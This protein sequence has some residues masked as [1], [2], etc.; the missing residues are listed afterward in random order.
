MDGT[1]RTAQRVVVIGGGVAGL[2]VAARLAQAGVPVTLLEASRLGLAASTRNQGWL[3]SGAWFALEQPELARMCFESLDV[4]RRFCPDCLDD[5]HEGMAFLISKPDTLATTWT[6][7]W[8]GVGIPFEEIPRSKLFSLVDG[9][10]QSLVHHAWLLPDRAFRP[11]VLLTR[12]ASAATNAGA[13]IRTET[14][15]SKL[16]REGDRVVEVLTGTGETIAARFVILA[17]DA[18]GHELLSEYSADVPG[19]QPSYTLVAVKSHLMAL[20][21]E[22]CSLPFCVVDRGGFNHVPHGPASVFG[23]NRW[24]AVPDFRDQRVEP[25]EI[26][27]LRAEIQVLFPR[28]RFD[29]HKCIEWAGT[30][31]QAMHVEQ[32]EP[33]RVPKPTVIDH[34]HESPKITNL[35]SLYPGRASLWPHL[36]EDAL[37]IVHDKLELPLPA[38]AVPP[39]VL[40]PR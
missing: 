26:E 28:L 25:Q 10:D 27:R 12:L 19:W 4:T 39:Y 31:V 21:P 34:A 2:S 17:A 1:I 40:P 3:Y 38:T 11:D 23:A 22:V 8:T 32:I 13:E 14:P 7:A 6:Q 30:M 9:L 33:G 35:L 18:G 15:V 36:A 29:D 37:K 20:E 5:R 16:V 24:T